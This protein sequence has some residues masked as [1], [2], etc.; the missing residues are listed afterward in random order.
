MP[1]TPAE[2]RA[3]NLAQLRLGCEHCGD[4]FTPTSNRQRW[5]KTCVPNKRARTILQRYGI[6]A[7]QY[8]EMVKRQAGRCLIC[9]RM[10]T[11]LNVD[12]D[13]ATG[14][15]RGLLCNACNPAL[16]LVEQHLQAALIYLGLATTLDERRIH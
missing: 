5:C 15:V 4:T 13:H 1:L 9:G 12:H 11:R 14:A 8:D 16:H 10:A 2:K 6:S 7:E 3:L